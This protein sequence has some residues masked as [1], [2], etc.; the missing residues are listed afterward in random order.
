MPCNGQCGP[1][2]H[3]H[4][5][6]HLM[7]YK[8]CQRAVSAW[9]RSPGNSVPLMVS[10]YCHPSVGGQQECAQF[11]TSLFWWYGCCWVCLASCPPW[12]VLLA[13]SPSDCLD[14]ISLSRLC[15]DFALYLSLSGFG[16]AL[17]LAQDLASIDSHLALLLCLRF[18]K[19]LLNHSKLLSIFSFSSAAFLFSSFSFSALKF[20][21]DLRNLYITL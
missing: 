2:W 19:L 20:L 5:W 18:T 11:G 12:K 6:F 13:F 15:L 7:L 14:W 1:G 4:V 16:S 21:W 17:F 3:S 9:I 10:L 8:S